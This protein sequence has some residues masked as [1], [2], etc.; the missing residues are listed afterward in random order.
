MPLKPRPLR[1]AGSPRG[2][3]IFQPL[4]MVKATGRGGSSN[5]GELQHCEEQV[6]PQAVLPLHGCGGSSSQTRC[7][8]ASFAGCTT[9]LPSR[10]GWEVCWHQQEY[11]APEPVPPRLFGLVPLLIRATS[12]AGAPGP[13]VCLPSIRGVK[14]H[15]QQ[16]PREALISFV[17]YANTTSHSRLSLLLR[18]EAF[19][20]DGAAL[21]RAQRHRCFSG[22]LGIT[23][24]AP[25][26]SRTA[27]AVFKYTAAMLFSARQLLSPDTSTCYCSS[28]F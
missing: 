13:V 6:V 3:I 1:A 20:A 15:M 4:W 2:A 7:R 14:Q 5:A 16:F 27:Q 24:R 9:A 19:T 11:Q 12:P 22:T 25:S 8:A 17:S 28:K 23:A 26:S 18:K 21:R 10:S